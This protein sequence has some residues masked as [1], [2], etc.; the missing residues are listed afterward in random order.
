MGPLRTVTAIAGAPPLL[1]DTDVLIDY[2]RGQPDAVAYMRG[3]AAPLLVAAVTVAELYAG[4]RDGAERT[5]LDNFVKAFEVVPVDAQIAERGGPYRRD[6]GTGH[7][8]GLADTLIA[9]TADMRQATLV[10]LNA[11]HFP[12]L[13]NVVIPYR[14]P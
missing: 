7:A 11:R 12:M 8:T 9:A 3:L 2:L 14:K 5:A 4:V 6:Y 1:L 13:A 10:T